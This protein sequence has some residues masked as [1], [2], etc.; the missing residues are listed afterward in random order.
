[1]Q[2][3]EGDAELED[4]YREV[5][6]DYFRSPTHKGALPD[7]DI[8]SHGVNPVCGDEIQLTMSLHNDLVDKIRFSGHGCVISQASASMMAEALEGKT[9]KEADGLSQ[10]FKAMMLQG[11]A[12]PC[13][14]EALE[15]LKALE[16]VRKFPVRIKCALLAWN[17]L[18]QGLQ[19]RF[20][21]KIQSEFEENSL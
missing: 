4:L 9:L 2:V 3:A 7:A 17:T 5:L 18:L 1:M 20:R 16:G 15:D 14:P 13:L 21:G 10:A 11:F 12:V 19:D 8:R 6:I